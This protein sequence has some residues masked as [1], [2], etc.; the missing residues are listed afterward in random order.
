MKDPVLK[1]HLLARTEMALGRIKARRT[2]S[3]VTLSAIALVFVLLGLGML[4]FSG[5]HAFAVRFSPALAGLFIAIIDIII[6]VVIFSLAGRT[7]RDSNEEK[8]AKEIR[9]L[10]YSELNAD[11]DTLKAEFSKVSDDV[12]RIRSGF[13]AITSGS[14]GGLSGIVPLLGLLTTAVKKKRK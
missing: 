9:D 7:G 4:N 12:H 5:Y 14:A 11:V 13:S 6:A 8:M 1:L 2:A 3:Q 10:A